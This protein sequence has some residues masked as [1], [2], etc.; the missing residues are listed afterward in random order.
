MNE[1]IDGTTCAAGDCGS[2]SKWSLVKAALQGAL[3]AYDATVRWSLKFFASVSTPSTCSVSQGVEIAPAFSN[4]TAISAKLDT[5]VASSSTPTTAAETAGASY[6]L[7]VADGSPKYILLITDGI[8]TCGVQAC[9]M[10]ATGQTTN[11]CDDANA[12]AAVK[13]ARDDG[14]IPTMV[15]G[16]GTALGIG[17]ATLE[18]MAVAGGLARPSS[19]AYYPLQTAAD[20]TAAIQALTAAAGL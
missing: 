11:Q 18:N 12:I 6:L 17:A 2:N 3:P 14:G 20:L 15:V 8:P 19:P 1:L 16:I 9:P 13:A 7:T 10:D 5:V 4:S